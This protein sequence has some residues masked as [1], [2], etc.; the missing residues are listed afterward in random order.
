MNLNG[1][2]SIWHIICARSL[3]QTNKHTSTLSKMFCEMNRYEWNRVVSIP[4]AWYHLTQSHAYNAIVFGHFCV[5]WFFCSNERYDCFCRCRRLFRRKL[6]NE[7]SALSCHRLCFFD[8][9]VILAAATSN[10]SSNNSGCLWFSL[11]CDLIVFWTLPWNQLSFSCD[12]D[13]SI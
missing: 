5:R 10:G 11:S 1:F 13:F 9:N 8:E 3:A 12:T 7:E 6:L 2:R 4:V